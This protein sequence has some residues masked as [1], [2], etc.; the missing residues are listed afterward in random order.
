MSLLGPFLLES[1]AGNYD[2]PSPELAAD[3]PN[4]LLAVGGDLS[5]P[6]L[7]AAYRLGIFPWFSDD[8]PILWWTPDPRAVLFPE[9]LKVSR[10]LRK[11]LRKG[12]FQVTLDKAFVD[13]IEACSL[14]RPTLNGEESGT[15][16]TNEMKRAYIHL[17]ELG[18]AHSAECW[19]EGELVGGLYGVAIGK[20]FFGES[21]F[22]QVSDA[23]K[24]AFVHLVRQ[25]QK[26][27][28]ALID[29]QVSSEHLK[30]LGAEE[31]PR[32]QFQKLLEKY[33]KESPLQ[34]GPWQM[35]IME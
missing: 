25:L 9:Q 19:L 13:V 8:Q 33:C 34:P 15:W 10:S 32:S 2:F 22:T 35:E 5:P 29:C 20:V 24:V 6:R 12:R 17:H 4:G 23:S 30:S 11:T 14:P 18:Y 26:W 7:L 27:G 31:I 1:G 21:M 3:E 16:I 28:F